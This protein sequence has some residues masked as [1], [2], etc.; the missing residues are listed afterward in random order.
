MARAQKRDDGSWLLG[1]TNDQRDKGI[2]SRDIKK[3]TQCSRVMGSP[4]VAPEQQHQHVGNLLKIQTH[5][6]TP[7][8]LS[9]NLQALAI[10][11]FIRPLG[12]SDSHSSVRSLRLGNRTERRNSKGNIRAKLAVAQG[13]GGGCLTRARFK[14]NHHHNKNP[15]KH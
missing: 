14:T 8:L 1:E 13:L 10:G 9:W 12:D 6:S 2:D 5:R 4:S 11:V 3:S 15:T 7:D